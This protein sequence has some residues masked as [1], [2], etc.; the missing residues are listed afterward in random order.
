MVVQFIWTTSVINEVIHAID[1]TQ[2]G[3]RSRV[4]RAKPLIA[5]H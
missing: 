2:T 5:Q 3:D 1:K 4:E